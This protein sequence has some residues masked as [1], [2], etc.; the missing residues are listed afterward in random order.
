MGLRLGLVTIVVRDYDDAKAFYLEKLGF[1]LIEDTSLGGGKRWLVVSPGPSGARIL[2]AKAKNAAE[3]LAI[4]NQTGGRVAMFLETDD[5]GQ[6]HA[7]MIARGVTFRGEP[8][9]ES[10]GTVAVFEDIYGNLFDLI[11]MKRAPV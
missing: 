6:T 2:L 8:R 7:A 10:Y 11:E 1:S 5:F 4:G 9:H 3:R